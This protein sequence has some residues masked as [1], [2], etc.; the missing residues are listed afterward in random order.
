MI[1]TWFSCLRM[2]LNFYR[3]ICSTRTD[4]AEVIQPLQARQSFKVTVALVYYYLDFI[5]LG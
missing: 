5:I 3:L 4:S 1:K 2:D